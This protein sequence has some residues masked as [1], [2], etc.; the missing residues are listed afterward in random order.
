MKKKI[1]LSVVPIIA[2]SSPILIASSCDNTTKDDYFEKRAKETDEEIEKRY[3]NEYIQKENY[4]FDDF[5]QFKFNKENIFV[6]TLIP[7]FLP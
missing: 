4:I 3:I 6:R 2:I 5:E 1:L 7:M